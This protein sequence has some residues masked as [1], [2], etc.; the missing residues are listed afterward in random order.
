MRILICAHMADACLLLY[1]PL[2]SDPDRTDAA[3]K[4]QNLEREKERSEAQ[5]IVF[6]AE[7][8]WQIAG[9]GR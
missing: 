8:R 7:A 4:K 6:C 1:F 9:A 3:K 2:F 5:M